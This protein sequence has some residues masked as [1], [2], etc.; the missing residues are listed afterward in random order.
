MLDVQLLSEL[1]T[2]KNN[3]NVKNQMIQ[4]ITYF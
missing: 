2:Y 4:R 3:K 1:E